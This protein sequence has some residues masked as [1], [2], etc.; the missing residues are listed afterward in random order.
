MSE[1]I[2]IND[3]QDRRRDG[4]DGLYAEVGPNW[5]TGWTWTVLHQP[6]AGGESIE[7]EWGNTTDETAARREADPWLDAVH[8][9]NNV[10]PV[11]VS[12]CLACAIEEAIR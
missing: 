12:D 10:D 11:P 1:W 2:E 4:K 5:P 8:L 7:I 3:G 6:E 9:C